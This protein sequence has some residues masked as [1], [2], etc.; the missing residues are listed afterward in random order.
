MAA[1][2][3]ADDTVIVDGLRGQWIV[4]KIDLGSDW[5]GSRDRSYVSVSQTT[6]H[7]VITTQVVRVDDPARIRFVRPRNADMD[8]AGLDPTPCDNVIVD[9]EVRSLASVRAA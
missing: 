9:G 7:R 1:I 6:G 4:E 2:I 8:A 3:A 5:G